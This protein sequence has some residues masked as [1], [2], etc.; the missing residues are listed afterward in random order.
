M[1]RNKLVLSTFPV[2]QSNGKLLPANTACTPAKYAG[3]EQP[4][5]RASTGVM[6]VGLAAFSSS[7][8]GPQLVPSK[9]LCLVPPTS[10]PKGHNAHR[11]ALGNC[12]QSC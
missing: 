11:W 7:F 10:T 2:S 5:P 1:F 3:A 4:D 9:R 12:Y 6:M 8:F